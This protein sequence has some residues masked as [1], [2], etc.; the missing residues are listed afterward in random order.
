MGRIL[1]IITLHP[2][3]EESEFHI[4]ELVLDASPDSGRKGIAT[5]IGRGVGRLIAEQGLSIPA[6]DIALS[7]LQTDVLELLSNSKWEK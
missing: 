7:Q 4:E 2:S 3:K 6:N 5:A 1:P